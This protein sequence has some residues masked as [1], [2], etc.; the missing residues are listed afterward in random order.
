MHI[1]YKHIYG[2]LHSKMQTIIFNRYAIEFESAIPAAVVNIAIVYYTFQLT[3]F[4]MAYVLQ[5][6]QSPHGIYP[7]SIVFSLYPEVV[8]R[9]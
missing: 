5:P 2:I 9:L 4:L 3:S 8:L 1:I 7:N 6:N